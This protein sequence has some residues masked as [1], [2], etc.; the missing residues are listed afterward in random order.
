MS[1]PS[2]RIQRIETLGRLEELMATS[3]HRPVWIFKH[4]LTCP[5]SSRA[6]RQY[7]KFVE[8][9]LVEPPGDG[10]VGD[11]SVGD[12]SAGDGS[13]GPV[14]ALVEVQKVRPVSNAIAERT[15]VP[16][17]SPQ[18]LLVRDS[19]VTW[20]ASHWKIKASALRGATG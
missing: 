3:A 5:V 2:S 16:H 14:F 17:Q 15:G 6:Y 12:G 7:E 4:S 13:T 11:G 20:H 18:A 19:E 1:N 10:S 8:E 9:W